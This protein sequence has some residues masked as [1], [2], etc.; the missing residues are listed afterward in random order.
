MGEAGRRRA[1]KTA[2][3]PPSLPGGKARSQQHDD[4]HQT[5]DQ[6]GNSA[7]GDVFMQEDERQQGEEN[8]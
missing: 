4:T 5:N 8:G 7:V 2:E 1:E 6:H 3:K